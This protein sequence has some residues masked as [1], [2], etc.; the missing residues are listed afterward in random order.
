MSV[1]IVLLCVLGGAKI[2]QVVIKAGRA[3]GMKGFAS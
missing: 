2:G 3:L 1:L